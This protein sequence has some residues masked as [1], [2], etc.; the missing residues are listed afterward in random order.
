MVKELLLEAEANVNAED[1][2]GGTAL[3]AAIRQWCSS[4]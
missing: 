3:L 2:G 1:K 4:C